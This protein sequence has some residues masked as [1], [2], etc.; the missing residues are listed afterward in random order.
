MELR[1]KVSFLLSLV[2]FAACAPIIRVNLYD[3]KIRT[4]KTDNIEV[5]SFA[6][7]IPFNYKEIGLITVDDQGWEKSE[8][9]LLNK[10][11][12][13]AQE[14]GADGILILSQDKQTDGYVPVG[15]MA[16][17][18]NRRVIRTSAIVKISDK[19]PTSVQSESKTTNYNTSIADE[20]VK[21]KKLKDD[22]VITENEFQLQKAKL[23][24]S[25]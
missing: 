11:I 1:I 9:E 2:F 21:L 13:K 5:Y 4:P 23:F 14:L 20:I 22:G 3:N 17:A 25:K 15:N 8:T 24:D 10:A 6:Q 7:A 12:R 18:V 16:V 19:S